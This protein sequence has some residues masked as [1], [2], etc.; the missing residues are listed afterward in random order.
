MARRAS[1]LVVSGSSTP[2]AGNSG[3][4]L[5]AYSAAAGGA[6]VIGDGLT[7]AFDADRYIQSSIF[8]RVIHDLWDLGVD[9]GQHGILEW[10]TDQS[11]AIH[12]RVIGSDGSLY[13]A[14]QANDGR[15][16]TNSSN[17][18]YWAEDSGE[19]AS[20]TT[21]EAGTSTSAA[22]TPSGLLSL[23]AASPNA[24][25]QGTE[26]EFGLVR[27][28][29][30][31]EV[32]A[33]TSS[34]RVVTPAGLRRNLLAPLA[35]PELTGDPTA[36]TQANSDNSTKIA[37]TAF[38]KTSEA[39]LSIGTNQIT[40]DAVTQAK[41][42]DDVSFVEYVHLCTTNTIGA[43]STRWEWGSLMSGASDY[44]RFYTDG[45]LTT[46]DRVWVKTDPPRG[47]IGWMVEL[48]DGSTFDQRCF[49]PTQHD[50]NSSIYLPITYTT[51]GRPQILT[52]V[53]I[54]MAT[55][56]EPVPSGTGG[57]YLNVFTTGQNI[58]GTDW[59]CR[60]YAVVI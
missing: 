51:S 39:N 9:I 11:Y 10:H 53:R 46:H 17:S 52:G 35:S 25:W 16:P 19:I 15:D 26:D 38:V 45:L 8:N 18:A 32:D 43:T 47:W 41:L 44:V 14:V 13:R 37:T 48:Y 59:E 23:F 49:L 54:N 34:V 58:S 5:I 40:D 29:T 2:W 7:T 57:W 4:N 28:A 24:R 56:S 36:P 50:V 55:S 42:H 60:L 3:A 27:L 12:A 30:T 6:L 20:D 33:G 22:V 21:V 1:G 31:T